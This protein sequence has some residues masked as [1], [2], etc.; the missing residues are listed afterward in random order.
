MPKFPVEVVYE[1]R[2]EYT[3][4]ADNYSDAEVQAVLRAKDELAEQFEEGTPSAEEFDVTDL[5]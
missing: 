1:W 3:V 5:G 2:R 4:D